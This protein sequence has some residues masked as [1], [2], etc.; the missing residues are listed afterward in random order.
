MSTTTMRTNHSIAQFGKSNFY[1]N[2][3]KLKS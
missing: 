3:E 1:E 2:D